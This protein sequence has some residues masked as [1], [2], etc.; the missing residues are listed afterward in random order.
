MLSDDVSNIENAIKLLFSVLPVDSREHLLEDLTV[1]GTRIAPWQKGVKE[2]VN[3]LG[4]NRHGQ[5]CYCTSGGKCGCEMCNG[6]SF[7]RSCIERG[8][9]R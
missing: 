9:P 6:G 5:C 7:E 3:V 1:S 2:A 8:L 4:E